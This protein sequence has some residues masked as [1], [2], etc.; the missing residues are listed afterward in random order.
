V[1]TIIVTGADAGYLPL[2]EDL[3][4]SIRHQQGQESVDIGLLDCGLDE[5]SRERLKNAGILVR[6]PGWDYDFSSH[7]AHPPNHM[8]AQTARPRLPSH[9]PGYDLYIWLDADTWVQRWDAVDLYMAAAREYG[10]SAAPEVDRSYVPIYGH[11][12][13]YDCYRRCISGEAARALALYPIVNSGAFAAIADAPHW[14]LWADLL[15]RISTINQEAFFFAEQTALNAIIRRGRKVSTAFLPA[16]CNWMCHRA[17]P[18][19][20]DDGLLLLEPNPPTNH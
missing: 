18:I 15:G 11:N 8:K 6:D 19:L 2:A 3:I 9:F 16:I 20:S 17:R 7:R 4:A 12:W 13:L 14:K 1:N 10:F 5:A